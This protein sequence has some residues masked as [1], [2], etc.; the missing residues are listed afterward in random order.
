MKLYS[1]ITKGDDGSVNIT[2]SGK[3]LP[4]DRNDLIELSDED[5]IKYDTH[6]TYID[7][8]SLNGETLEIDPAKLLVKIRANIVVNI[9]DRCKELK[10]LVT[11][12]A[13]LDNKEVAQEI[14][15]TIKTLMLFP[16]SEIFSSNLTNIDDILNISCP[17]L[18]INHQS[19]YSNK[20]YGI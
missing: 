3:P 6:I 12:A 7:C 15:S 19:L 16:N 1:Y 20:L 17:E 4:L 11:Q 2:Y 8:C 9:N 18:L 5:I 10:T 13:V 14:A